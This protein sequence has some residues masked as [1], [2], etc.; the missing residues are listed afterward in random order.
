MPTHAE[1]AGSA[2]ATEHRL[3][4]TAAGSGS[5][6]VALVHGFA[7]TGGCFGPFGEA[8][9]AAHEVV[10]VDQPGHGG[11]LRHLHADLQEAA[12]LLVRT[13]GDAVLVGYSM[14]A[15][16]SLTAALGHPQQVGALVLIG[17]TAGIEDPA[18]RAARRREDEGRAARLEQ[19]G[20]GAFLA[21]WLSMPMF[22]GLPKW[23]RFD[24][25][26]R[27]NTVE[28]LAASLRRAGTGSMT[29]LWD[30]LGELR[31]PVL[32][33]TGAHDERY[34][35][36]AERLVAAVGGPAEHVVVHAAGHA[37][38]LEQPAA[39]AEA[40]LAFLREHGAG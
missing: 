22:A 2:A 23:A 16:L 19:V 35:G 36:L 20:L 26:R 32:C 38:H 29:P 10:R 21:E 30:R 15:R 17:G 9:E 3:A 31:C 6:T 40:V 1:P 12:E 11:S 39:A 13:T 33:L 28:G 37:A 27:R 5:P 4:S 25:E 24:D 18:E 14:G 34:G 7:Q 8:I